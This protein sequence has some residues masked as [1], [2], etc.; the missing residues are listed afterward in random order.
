MN[1]WS[2]VCIYYLSAASVQFLY[3][4]WSISA[5]YNQKFFIYFFRK[6]LF[7]L[8]ASSPPCWKRPFTL[9]QLPTID[10]IT[11]ETCM[12]TG[13]VVWRVRTPYLVFTSFKQSFLYPI[14][15][16]IPIWYQRC[17]FISAWLGLGVVGVGFRDRNK[18]GPRMAASSYDFNKQRLNMLLLLHTV[19]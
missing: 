3:L 18:Y 17:L 2:I 13:A 15:H 7:T 19:S 10:T 5:H 9:T 1:R 14:L 12:V 6:C 11:K 8:S 16:P 4:G